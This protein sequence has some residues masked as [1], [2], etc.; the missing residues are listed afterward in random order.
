MKRLA[1]VA[2]ALVAGCGEP[3]AP[4]AGLDRPALEAAVKACDGGGRGVRCEQARQ[5]LADARREDRLATYRQA[6]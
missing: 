1:L 4:T 2:A 3:A 6:F 5:A